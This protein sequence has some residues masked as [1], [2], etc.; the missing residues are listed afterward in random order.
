VRFFRLV[1]YLG[2]VLIIEYSAAVAQAH[3]GGVPQLTN[4]EAGPY[5]VSVWTQ[6]DP[7]QVGKAHFTVAIS[8]PPALGA[9]QGEAGSP[10]LGAI[11]EL[12]LESENNTN[13][14]LVGLATHESAINKLFYEADLELPAEGRWSVT[15][16]VDGPAGSGSVSFEIEVLSANSNQLWLLSGLGLVLLAVGWAVQR[17]FWKRQVGG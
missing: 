9:A 10:V 6:P 3:G 4:A 1:I 12:H 8:E 16:T 15:V 7:L 2:L 11:V 13:P 14:A 5:R 17:W